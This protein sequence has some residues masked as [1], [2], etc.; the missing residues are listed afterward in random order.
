MSEPT[1]KIPVILSIHVEPNRRIFDAPEP[2]TGY[3]GT[4]DFFRS[5][6]PR[7]ACATGVSAH[8]VWVFR[9]DQQI[10]DV[11]GS[12]DWVA[13]HYPDQIRGSKSEGDELGLH[14]HAWRRD[15]KSGRWIA[16]YGDQEWV[17]HCVRLSF[18]TFQKAFG[19]PC[20]TFQS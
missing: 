2:W 6:R 9:M 3:E 10:A 20:R 17:D 16:D 4:W 5:V 11:F 8:Y 12:P 14:T 15:P 1:A 18:E 7:L 19:Q 13:A